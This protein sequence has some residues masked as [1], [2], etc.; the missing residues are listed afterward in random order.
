[1]Q[2]AEVLELYPHTDIAYR[3]LNFKLCTLNLKHRASN[4]E[5]KT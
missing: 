4:I 5:P 3:T 2:Q 1:M